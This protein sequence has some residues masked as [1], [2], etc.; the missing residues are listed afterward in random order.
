MKEKPSVGDCICRYHKGW[1]ESKD[2]PSGLVKAASGQEVRGASH[3]W[4]GPV[5]H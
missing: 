2:P 3:G 4:E 5:S 1:G